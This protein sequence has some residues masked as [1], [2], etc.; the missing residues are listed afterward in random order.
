MGQDHQ[1]VGYQSV[2]SRQYLG[3]MMMQEGGGDEGGGRLVVERRMNWGLEQEGEQGQDGRDGTLVSSCGRS[4]FVCL[5]IDG[6]S[7]LFSLPFPFL[8]L[9]LAFICSSLICFLLFSSASFCSSTRCS[10]SFFFSL[11]H[12]SWCDHEFGFQFADTLD[13][14]CA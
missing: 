12:S 7:L 9:T 14:D 10:F 8:S 1:T 2:T 11:D 13:A 6:F 5:F 4:F 3:M